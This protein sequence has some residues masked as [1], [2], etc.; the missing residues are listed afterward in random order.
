MERV[1][2]HTIA[3]AAGTAR[4]LRTLRRARDI[5]RWHRW[6][7][8]LGEREPYRE[9]GTV[10][11]DYHQAKQMGDHVAVVFMTDGQEAPPRPLSDTSMPGITPGEVRGWL[12]GVG[13]DQPAP[14]PKTDSDGRPAGFWLASDV[15]QT[16]AMSSAQRGEVSHEELSAL[17]GGYLK[18]LGGQT[19][20]EY[21]G[22]VDRGGAGGCVAR[23]AVCG[24]GW[25]DGRC[26][27]VCCVGGSRHARDGR[28]CRIFAGR[29]LG[30]VGNGRLHFLSSRCW[31]GAYS[32]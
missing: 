24:A 10:F 7:D 27:L 3:A 25:F 11:R 30:L 32:N 16:S 21:R 5:A 22:V 29:V 19:G 26:P 8:A 15:V 4:S 23:F 6:T 17:R 20:L 12:I 1:H 18:A 31:V 14:I 9:R 28:F 2:W 13:G